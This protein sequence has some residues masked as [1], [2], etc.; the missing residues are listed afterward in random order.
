MFK[1]TGLPCHSRPSLAHNL[2]F[3]LCTL[4]WYER[5]GQVNLK[6]YGILAIIFQ[7]PWLAYLM[8]LKCAVLEELLKRAVYW[9]WIPQVSWLAAFRRS[10]ALRYFSLTSSVQVLFQNGGL[11]TLMLDVWL[12]HYRHCNFCFRPVVAVQTSKTKSEYWIG[13]FTY[14]YPN[15]LS[16]ILLTFCHYITLCGICLSYYQFSLGIG[17]CRLHVIS[18]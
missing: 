12:A 17:L 11:L 5:L 3:F 8:L 9:L 2:N 10:I 7:I 6:Y 18:F 1:N 15:F 16:I 13:A 14:V 4:P